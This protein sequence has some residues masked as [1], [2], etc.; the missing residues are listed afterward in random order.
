VPADLPAAIGQRIRRLRQ[1]LNISQE[2]LAERA[3][4]HRNYVGSVE[5][6][7]RDI[8]ITS[9]GRL[10]RALGISLAEFFQPFRQR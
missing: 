3:D 6:G 4:L 10:V 7:E 8:G 9:L 1:E 5:R 2:E